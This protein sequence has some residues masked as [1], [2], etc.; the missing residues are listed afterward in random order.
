MPNIC[1]HLVPFDIEAGNQ[2]DDDHL[3]YSADNAQMPGQGSTQC[4]CFQ[5]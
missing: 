1:G 3:D 4:F 2:Q 5:N